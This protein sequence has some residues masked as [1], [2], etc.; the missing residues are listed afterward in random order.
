MF[1]ETKGRNGLISLLAAMACSTL[2]VANESQVPLNSNAAAKLKWEGCGELNNHTLECKTLY[3]FWSQI[4]LTWIGSRL[5]VP[6][7]H[8]TP[9]DKTFSIP[10]IRMLA[11]N[12]SA[13]G[14]R[15]ILL[16]PGGPGGLSTSPKTWQLL[17][18]FLGSGVS[19][20]R[21]GAAN[22]NK[23][24]GE[25]FHLLSFDPRGNCFP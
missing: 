16:N 18:F 23:I 14:D 11:T 2:V 21:R 10:L 19:F 20:L 3:R 13:T 15:H 22:L 7:D 25:E 24:I 17:I 12:A 6:M 5:D 8:N 9:G 4:E 1:N